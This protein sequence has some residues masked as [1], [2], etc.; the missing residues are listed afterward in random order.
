MWCLRLASPQ[1]GHYLTISFSIISLCWQYRLLF[2]LSSFLFTYF[3]SDYCELR[4]TMEEKSC[5]LQ[6]NMLYLTQENTNLFR[7]NLTV[8]RFWRATVRMQQQENFNCNTFAK[9]WDYHMNY[10]W[11]E[12]LFFLEE[13]TM[14]LPLT[15]NLE[16]TP[17]SF[18][19]RLKTHLFTAAFDS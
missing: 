19:S 3:Q 13:N 17:S 7:T 1:H 4:H 11:S 16:Q 5:I 9:N 12:C 14:S 18:K 10:D 6:W 2:F 15:T 8:V